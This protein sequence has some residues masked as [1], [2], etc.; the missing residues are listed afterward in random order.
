MRH[1]YLLLFA[2]LSVQ[3]FA[4]GIEPGLPRFMTEEEQA[5]LKLQPPA[6]VLAAG[7]TNPPSEPVRH[8]GEWEELQ[9]LIIT[10]RSHPA[11][12]TE[13]VRAAREECRVI[14]CC[15]NQTT[16]NSAQNALTAAGV[17]ISSNVE[18]VIVPNDSIWVRD[19]GP[20]C[21]YANDVDSLYLVD[22]IYN[23]PTRKKDDT[24]ARTIAPYLS[25]PLFET[26][27]APTD[28]VN[29]GGNFMSDG[30]GTAFASELILDEN[31]LGNPYNVT[32]K[33]E[34]Q[35]NDILHDFMGIERYIK[36]PTLPY[37]AIH[38]IDM[39]MKLLDEETL[40][41]GQY[42]AG[43]ADGPQIEANIQYVLSN[44][45]SVFGTPYRVV[46]I[47]MPPDY[48]NAYP[49]QNGDY[50]TYAN[51]V[52]VNKTVIVPFYEQEFDTTAQRIWEETM[53]GYKI[54]GVDCNAII[55]SLGAIHCITK[56]IGVN[57]PIHIVHQRLADVED[58]NVNGYPV[59]AHI[60]HRSG[61]SN[62][63]VWYTTDLSQSWQ[64][65]PM[66]PW[67]PQNIDT[68]F[69]WLAQIP[70]Q[71]AGSTVYY[72]IE[73][74]SV[75]G[76]TAVRPM[77]A[78][79]G[80][81]KFRINAASAVWEAPQSKLLDIYPNPA[82]AIT[83]IPVYTAAPTRC[84]IVVYNALGQ[85]VETVFEGQIPS[86]NSN[87]FIDAATYPSGAYFVELRAGDQLSVKKLV[88]R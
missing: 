30:F 53:P 23:R 51:A 78:P 47:P 45:T 4:Q 2:F 21:V 26:S 14:I 52:F 74:N 31:D 50:R 36:M 73:A 5:T 68:A 82:S 18:F 38:H 20:N 12:L 55:P 81:W 16:V 64:A 25:L 70:H 15:S 44:Y 62:A 76:K 83:C 28:L 29:T 49:N 24:L 7:F 57:D 61:I 48:N 17:D 22:W 65:V 58:N 79:E 60:R 11:I 46:R 85:A 19:Y 88:V 8:M 59:F 77:P 33:D 69:V 1:L 39:H 32:V 56:E 75:S 13:I 27:A 42:P 10:W 34:A 84:S 66:F 86:G 72:Y 6:P 41:V 63:K 3:L 80:W 67:D 35:I 37:D 71:A 9:A 54:V 40:L 43:T 87:Y